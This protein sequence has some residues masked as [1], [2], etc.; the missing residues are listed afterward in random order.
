MVAKVVKV[1]LPMITPNLRRSKLTK[2]VGKVDQH[3]QPPHERSQAENVS[4]VGVSCTP[5]DSK[6]CTVLQTARVLV[7]GK[8][9]SIEDTLIPRS[10]N[11]YICSSLVHKVG[12]SWISS[13]SMAYAA[14]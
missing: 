8:K 12:P 2:L 9:G 1:P 10:D 6:L 11:S 3:D 4:H 13:Q 7:T 5:K 14:W